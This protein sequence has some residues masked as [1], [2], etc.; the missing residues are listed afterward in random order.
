[1]VPVDALYIDTLGSPFLSFYDLLMMNTLYGCLGKALRTEDNIYAALIPDKCRQRQRSPEQIEIERYPP[2]M[3]PRGL[4]G[5]FGG[6]GGPP[7][8]FI[9]G[10]SADLTTALAL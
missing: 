8:G 10:L 2:F 7:P 3:G 5:G 6:F 9:G 1:M 4:P